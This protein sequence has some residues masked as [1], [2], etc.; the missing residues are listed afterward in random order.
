MTKIIQN[1]IGVTFCLLTITQDL[2]LFNNGSRRVLAKCKCGSEREYLLNNIKTG[3]T[4]SCGC[5]VF[6]NGKN[7]LIHGLSH[8]KLHHVWGSMIGRCNNPKNKKYKDY[9]GRGVVVCDEWASNFK[10]FYD[11]A[12]DKWAEG[13]Q[14]DKDKLGNGLLYS[15]NTCCFISCKENQNNKRSNVLIGYKGEIK[16]VTQWATLF[17]F[18]RHLIFRRLKNGW[19]IDKALNT[20]LRNIKNH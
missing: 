15:P 1:S 20:P 19:N 10:S 17:G 13:L 9:G 14:L 12:I 6:G 18:S 16:T 3:H 8:H 2:G 5:L 4:K 7:L 11:W